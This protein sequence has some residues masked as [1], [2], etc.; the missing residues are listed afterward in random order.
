MTT[1]M[2]AIDS[3]I[4]MSPMVSV[5]ES[6]GMRAPDGRVQAP[7]GTISVS[8]GA[9]RRASPRLEVQDSHTNVVTLSVWRST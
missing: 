3:A 7:L 9:P 2:A 4:T 6:L 5:M 1:M 8:G